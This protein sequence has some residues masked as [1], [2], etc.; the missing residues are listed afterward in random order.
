MPHWTCDNCH[1]QLEQYHRERRPQGMF[2]RISDPKADEAHRVL[3][4]PKSS[5][6]AIYNAQEYLERAK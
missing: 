5:A 1:Q 3:N 2:W 4:N 6:K